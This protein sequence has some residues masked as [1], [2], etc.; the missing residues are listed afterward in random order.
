MNARL[1]LYLK[2]FNEQSLRER[3]LIAVTAL[4]VVGFL[5][6]AYFADPRQRQVDT[7]RVENQQIDREV[8]SSRAA[9]RDLRQRIADGVHIEK[10]VQLARLFEEL[11]RLEDQLRVKTI[12]LV[13][14][15]DMFRLMGQLLSRDSKLKLLSLKRREVKAAIPQ[16]D[17]SEPAEEPAIFRHVLEIELAGKYIDILDY[18]Q[19]LEQLDWKLLWDEIDIVSEEYPETTV[20]LVM[21]TLSTRKEWVGI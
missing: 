17:V 1:G 10:E 11:E 12:E 20:K 3:A 7:L 2:K 19:S 4:V 8:Q 14:P 15:E 6:W 5:W 21:S 18:A 13:D 9:I 16:D